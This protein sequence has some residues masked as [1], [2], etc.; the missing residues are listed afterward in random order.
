[1]TSLP[2]KSHLPLTTSHEHHAIKAPSTLRIPA[3]RSQSLPKGPHT[4]NQ[5]PHTVGGGQG[6]VHFRYKALY[7]RFGPRPVHQTKQG[8][9]CLKL[10]PT[11]LSQPDPY[12]A[13]Y[14]WSKHGYCKVKI[15]LSDKP[16]HPEPGPVQMAPNRVQQETCCQ[17]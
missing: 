3:L 11:W 4:D 12:R 1:M 16:Q 13:L 14:T 5:V 2:T 6:G 15:P 9:T 17:Y 7:S 8:V 10:A